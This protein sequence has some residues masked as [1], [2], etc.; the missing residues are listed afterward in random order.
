[1]ESAEYEYNRAPLSIHE[2]AKDAN[3][4]IEVW[5]IGKWKYLYRDNWIAM[6]FHADKDLGKSGVFSELD[7]H[8]LE[9]LNLFSSATFAG[10]ETYEGLP[11]YHFSFDTSNLAPLKNGWK[12]DSAQGKLL[13]SVDGNIPLY[14]QLTVKGNIQAKVNPS[15]GVDFV[16][17][18]ITITKA[19]SNI[20]QPVKIALP[21]S[22]PNL[23]V[24]PG[25]P[26]PSGT[27]LDHLDLFGKGSQYY[28]YV[29]QASKEDFLSFYQNLAPTNGWM[30]E[31]FVPLTGQSI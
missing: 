23:A 4:P 24:E 21:A 31:R 27:E 30:V 3:G 5:L 26:L 8:N 29:T 10:Q 16:P 6:P 22:Y 12:V 25:F 17:G 19:L 28:F 15:G 18:K 9:Y 7:M 13:V 11:V 20:N 14:Y 2:K 1:M